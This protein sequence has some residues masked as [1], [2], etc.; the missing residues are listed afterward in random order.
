MDSQRSG[1]GRR[2]S[3]VSR[4]SGVGS[5]EDVAT[6]NLSPDVRRPTSDVRRP[7]SDSRLPWVDVFAVDVR[8]LASLRIVLALTVLAD[9]GMRAVN[10]RAHYSDEGLLPR[11][12]LLENLDPWL[13][14]VA[15]VNGTPVFQGLLFTLT[16]IAAVGLLLGY[17]TRLMTVIVW[18]LVLSI[19]WRNPF[20]GNSADGL[21]RMLL[22]WSMFVPLGAAWSLD[23]QRG[24]TPQW[25]SV[26]VLSV[27]TA[28][29]LLQVAFMY[30]FTVILKSGREWRVDGSALYYALSI[31]EL[32]TPLGTALLQFPE[33]LKALTFLTLGIEIGAPLLLFSPVLSVPLRMA[34]IAAIVSLHVGIWL[35][36][37]LGIFPWLSA[38]CM[39]C[40][41]PSWFWDTLLPRWW[42]RLPRLSAAAAARQAA[43]RHAR[44]IAAS[45]GPWLGAWGSVRPLALAA[46][47]APTPRGSADSPAGPGLAD[48]GRAPA[49]RGSETPP[50]GGSSF[51]LNLAAG[52]C[53]LFVF[54]WNL[55]GV[56]PIRLTEDARAF[57]SSLG[58][59]Q[60]WT[61]FAPFPYNSSSWYFI[62]GTLR[63]GRQVDLVPF[64]FRGDQHDIT[65]ASWEKPRDMRDVFAHDERWRKY[66]E[67][68]HDESNA[69]LLLP[70]AQYLCRDWNAAAGGTPAELETLQVIYNWERTLPDNR[71]APAQQAVQWDHQC[72]ADS[73]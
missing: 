4:E 53:L 5:R 1:V 56:S 28:G 21:L 39:V 18:V 47:S 3:D 46:S 71:R 29:L 60:S 63:D 23:R 34:G 42:A 22:F 57:G 73:P 35:T 50:L 12:F 62:P 51:L 30:W 65:P 64:L 13:V 2:T 14:S 33:L 15:L 44:P 61:M 6:R 49:A 11:P 16:A 54:V 70:L 9:L 68:L 43:A 52:F 31:Q 45:L 58:L 10:L 27:A 40:F 25:P 7:T 19:Q 67:S 26:R 69:Y 32:A 24:L 59:G 41:L 55:S 72:F 20:I 38:S 66:F 36:L 17:R 37:A 8:S 48:A